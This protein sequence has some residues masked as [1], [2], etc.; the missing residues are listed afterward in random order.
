MTRLTQGRYGYIEFS[1]VTGGLCIARDS[2]ILAALKSAE[3]FSDTDGA[4]LRNNI[5]Q[6]DEKAEDELALT[7]EEQDFISRGVMEWTRHLQELKMTRARGFL[8]LF[9][10][11]EPYLYFLIRQSFHSG[12]KKKK[13]F[14]DLYKN[15]AL[16][17]YDRDKNKKYLDLLTEGSSLLQTLD[18][19]PNA[20]QVAAV[21]LEVDTK[22]SLYEKYFLTYLEARE[23]RNLLTHR[24]N[25]LDTRYI[26][27]LKNALGK[28]AQRLSKVLY[29]AFS[30]NSEI[31][32]KITEILGTNRPDEIKMFTSIVEKIAS[33]P[34]SSSGR[35]QDRYKISGLDMTPHEKYIDKASDALIFLIAVFWLHT[36]VDQRRPKQ[37]FS[38]SFSAGFLSC[39][40]RAHYFDENFTEV[41]DDLVEYYQTTFNINLS[42]EEV[43]YIGYVKFLIIVHAYRSKSISSSSFHNETLKFRKYL[44]P[45]GQSAE[46]FLDGCKNDPYDVVYAKTNFT[47][48]LKARLQSKPMVEFLWRAINGAPRYEIPPVGTPGFDEETS[49]SQ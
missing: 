15:F 10:L 31:S 4:L 43:F 9:S 45:Y 12:G 13:R 42:D 6:P 41:I 37:S 28:Q 3:D 27:S 2:V 33:S 25:N 40:F 30:L 20:L 16:G 1:G 48:E 26:A 36:A 11:F 34:L 8:Y 29:R 23:R 39:F 5:R 22:S 7:T 46:A 44:E 47:G 35:K 17:V 38:V 21:T 14:L 18:D 24:G 49:T 19:L 32:G